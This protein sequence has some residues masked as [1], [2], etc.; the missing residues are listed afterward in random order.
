[1]SALGLPSPPGWT[2]WD[3]ATRDALLDADAEERDLT[4]ALAVPVAAA[5]ARASEELAREAADAEAAARA[6]EATAAAEEARAR[7]EEVSRCEF[8]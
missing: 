3:A 2:A 7:A 5:V 1:M 8:M 6:L 4:S